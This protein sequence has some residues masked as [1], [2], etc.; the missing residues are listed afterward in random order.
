MAITTFAIFIK[1]VKKNY[2][3]L[4]SFIIH[5]GLILALYFAQSHH[6]NLS[7]NQKKAQKNKTPK[8]I[9]S[10][11]YTPPPKAKVEPSPKAKKKALIVKN[12]ADQANTN[13]NLNAVISHSDKKLQNITEKPKKQFPQKNKPENNPQNKPQNKKKRESDTIN[14]THDEPLK[15]PKV[16]RYAQLQ[17]LR[18]ALNN[19]AK[20]PQRQYSQHNQ[21]P[22]IFNPT[23]KT[24]PNSTSV[25]D[26]EQPEQTNTINVGGSIAITKGDDGICS[27]KED[28]TVYGVEDATSTQYFAC[29]ESKFDKSFRLHMKKVIQKLKR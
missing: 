18:S 26:Q 17:K 1:K 4:L 2:A 20:R 12:K 7:I 24:V 14:S 6:N 27:I 22:S 8:A 9:K 13:N 11:L 21:A 5:L 28:L 10:F 23:P 25:F 15:K 3:L 19:S 16:D 29:G